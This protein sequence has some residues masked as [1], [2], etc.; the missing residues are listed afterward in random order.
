ML[1]P[2]SSFSADFYVVASGAE[3]DAGDFPG[4]VYS[5]R[6]VVSHLKPGP[7]RKAAA[8]SCMSYH[9]YSLERRAKQILPAGTC[10]ARVWHL[11]AGRPTRTIWR[12]EISAC[13]LQQTIPQKLGASNA[14]FRKTR[15]F[16][17]WIFHYLVYYSLSKV[18]QYVTCVSCE[19]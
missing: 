14:G 16:Q 12:L 3:W 8:E 2:L 13:S 18:M 11:K 4:R 6:Y 19:S 10:T 5:I 15:G 1:T 17:C 9:C 7:F